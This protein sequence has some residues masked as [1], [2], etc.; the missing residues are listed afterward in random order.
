MMLLPK[1]KELS[2]IEDLEIAGFMEP[3][4]EVG[5]IIMMFSSITDGFTI[6]LA[7]VTGHGLE[8]GF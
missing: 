6:A 1:E 5:E 4:D 3:A 8:V 2:Q 7:D